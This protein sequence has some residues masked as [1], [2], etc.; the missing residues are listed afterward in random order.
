MTTTLVVTAHPDPHAFTRQWAKATVDAATGLGDTVLVSDLAE[1]GFD[2]I[3]S[4]RH[5]ALDPA[6]PFDVLKVQETAS[7]QGALPG[8]VMIEIAKLERADRVVFHFP[9]WWFAPPAMLK[10]WFERVLA[11]GRTHSVDRRF[12][13]GVF[14]GKRA[15][16][17][18]STGA[19][20]VESGPDGKEGDTRLH[21]W[22]AAYALRYLGFDVLEPRL[23]HGV[24]GY[25]TGTRLTDLESRLRQN[26]YYQRE[27]MAGF[28]TLPVMRF[29]ADSD[30]DA[31]R[32]RADAP[33]Y[34][35]FIRRMP[36][37]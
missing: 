15:L 3:E 14:R 9:L 30:F 4:P 2:A 29:N 18:V 24:H 5:Y 22:P 26:L 17:C 8:D 6:T 7:D 23:V 27:V 31:G 21:L 36:S 28:D 11:H 20:A 33:S 1:M 35:P 12:D 25:A 37:E 32:L 19:N 10:G 34:S 16:F 13:T